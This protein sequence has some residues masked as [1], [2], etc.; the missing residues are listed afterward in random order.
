MGIRK[1]NFSD[2][3]QVVNLYQNANLFA[4]KKDIRDWTKDGLEKYPSLNFVY[5]RNTKI[6]GSISAIL[7]KNKSVEINDI[8]VLKKYRSKKI[9]TNLMDAILSVLKKENVKRVSLWVHWS[10]AASIPFYYK[11]GFQIKKCMKTKNISG[12][13]DGED[14][15][16]LEK[17]I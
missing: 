6:V 14:I 7:I 9:G 13:P 4:K 12:V 5:E 8:V 17:F 3:S 2:L 1:T 11:F 10:N 15:I 16:Y